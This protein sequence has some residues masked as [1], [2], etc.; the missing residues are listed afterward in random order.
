MV[1]VN[2]AVTVAAVGITAA[3]VEPVPYTVNLS[4]VADVTLPD[5][6]VTRAVLVS[7]K[8]NGED[9]VFGSPLIQNQTLIPTE[10]YTIDGGANTTQNLNTIT[11]KKTTNPGQKVQV[12]YWRK[13]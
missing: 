3:E 10:S 4:N 9:I 8:D 5:I 7:D 1:T 11:F 12:L 13:I 6:E 2:A